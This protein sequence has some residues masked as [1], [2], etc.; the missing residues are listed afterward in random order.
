MT[1]DH[2]TPVSHPLSMLPTIALSIEGE[3]ESMDEM[4]SALLMARD[5][6]SVLNDEII[7][8]TIR[9]C[10]NQRALI[11]DHRE[12]L[13]RWLTASPTSFQR[14]KILRLSVITKKHK[15]LLKDVLALTKELSCG[16]I[17]AILRM[18]DSELGMAVFEGR[19]NPPFNQ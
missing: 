5:K 15:S 10:H 17:D 3:F 7:Q 19:M 8:R 9:L 18:D 2:T 4:Y 6:P 13:N 14:D 16:T 12:Q 11:P 1:D